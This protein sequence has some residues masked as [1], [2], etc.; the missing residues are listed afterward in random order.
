MPDEWTSL[1]VLS[2]T[3]EQMRNEANLVVC[4]ACDLAVDFPSLFSEQRSGVQLLTFVMPP[5]A[6]IWLWPLCDGGFREP[7][8]LERRSLQRLCRQ[9]GEAEGRRAYAPPCAYG[10]RTVAFAS[11]DAGAYRQF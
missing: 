9:A 7:R 4:F 2:N 3:R 6:S 10:L 11:L 1:G 8:G 5:P